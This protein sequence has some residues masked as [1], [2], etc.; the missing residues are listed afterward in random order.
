MEMEEKRPGETHVKRHDRW[1]G[2]VLYTV[3]RSSVDG[4]LSVEPFTLTLGGKGRTQRMKKVT[5]T[6]GPLLHWHPVFLI[7]HFFSAL[8]TADEIR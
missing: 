1:K 4:A 5:Y 2:M 8:A 6:R 3:T 7:P